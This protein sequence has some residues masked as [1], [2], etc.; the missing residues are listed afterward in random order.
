MELKYMLIYIENQY[1]YF[2]LLKIRVRQAH[3]TKN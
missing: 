3:T 2:D 1:Y